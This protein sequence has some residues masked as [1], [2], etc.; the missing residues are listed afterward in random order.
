G[1]VVIT[2]VDPSSQTQTVTIPFTVAY[3][4]PTVSIL[5]AASAFAGQA[6]NFSS[7]VQQAPGVNDTLT[8]QWALSDSTGNPV[9]TGTASTLPTFTVPSLPAPVSPQTSTTYALTLT[10][11]DHHDGT[12]STVQQ[13]TSF[14]VVANPSA[15]NFNFAAIPITDY[16]PRPQNW[17]FP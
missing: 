3:V 15:G 13:S 9:S 14:S 17:D 7:T 2:A 12:T 5:G 1:S 16:D 11:V 4:E 8:Y 6:I 10:V